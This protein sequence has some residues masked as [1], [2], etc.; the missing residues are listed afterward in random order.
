[1]RR[2][3]TGTLMTPWIAPKQAEAAGDT[4]ACA[5]LQPDGG[6]FDQKMGC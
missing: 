2:V 5:P 3:M 1:M 6:A 4:A